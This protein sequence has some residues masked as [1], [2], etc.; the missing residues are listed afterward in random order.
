MYRH[1]ELRSVGKSKENSI[2]HV[3]DIAA[4]PTT[5][6][7]L[8]TGPPLSIFLLVPG[9]VSS[10]TALNCSKCRHQGAMK[11]LAAANHVENGRRS[12]CA[13]PIR[14]MVFLAEEAED[15]THQRHPASLRNSTS[16]V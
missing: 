12:D 5:S 8:G 13:A 15:S 7:D 11:R 1:K 16:Y 4:G 3:G 14:C 9:V 10:G 2:D 6:H